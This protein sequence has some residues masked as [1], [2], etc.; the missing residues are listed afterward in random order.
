MEVSYTDE[1][2]NVAHRTIRETAIGTLI[3]FRNRY[4]GH[5]TPLDKP[6][7][8]RLYE[9]FKPILDNLLRSLGFVEDLT[10]FRA[11]R[12]ELYQLTGKNPERLP[13]KIPNKDDQSKVWVEHEDGRRLDVMP[14]FILPGQVAGADASTGVL[15]YEQFTGGKRVVFHGPD[16]SVWES[17]GD[18][19]VNLKSMIR[20]KEQEQPVV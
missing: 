19:L 20:L 2:G 14:F 10:M 6:T 13:G 3:N 4:L 9:Q 15:V 1:D 11:E 16:N 18:V 12:A 7:S 17:M 5:G 8:I